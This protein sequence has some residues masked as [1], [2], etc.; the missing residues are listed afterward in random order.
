M[1]IVS[2]QNISKSFGKTPIINNISLN[3]SKGKFTCLLGSSGSGKTTILFLRLTDI[4]INTP[5][6]FQV[7]NSS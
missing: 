2:L 5:T 6:N 7:V 4:K 1:P 3:F